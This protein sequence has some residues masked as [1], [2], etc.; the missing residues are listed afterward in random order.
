MTPKGLARKIQKLRAAPPI[1][2]SYERACTARGIGKGRYAS[3]REH[4]LGW[5][6][7]YN[8]PGAYNRKIRKGRPAEFSYNHIGCPPMLLYLAEAAGVPRA[9]VLAAKRAALEAGRSRAGHC[10][11]LRKVLPWG[12]IEQQLRG[13]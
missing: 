13:S 5:L 4:W 6:S 11:A 1:T 9:K 12:A 7:E 10:A 3:Q 8:G 2:A